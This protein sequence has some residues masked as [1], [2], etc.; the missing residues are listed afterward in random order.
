MDV[1]YG[2]YLAHLFG[3]FKFVISLNFD[4]SG[5]VIDSGNTRLNFLQT[6]YNTINNNYIDKFSKDIYEY[7][8]KVD[9]KIF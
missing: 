9:P 4:R 6:K 2:Y 8:I 5:F 3:R 7:L 1:N